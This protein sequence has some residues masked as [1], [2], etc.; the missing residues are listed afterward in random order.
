MRRAVA[1]ALV[2]AFAV[3]GTRAVWMDRMPT[4]GMTERLEFGALPHHLASGGL[5]AGP[6][7]YMPEPQEGCALIWG[8]ACAPVFAVAGPSR[9]SLRWCDILWHAGTAAL[10]ALLAYLAWGGA[11]ALLVG[12][13]WALAPPGVVDAGHDGWVSHI[14]GAALTAASLLA[15]AAAA[16][17]SGRRET[18]ALAGGGVAAS[19]ALFFYAD[20]VLALLPAALALTLLR[21]DRIRTVA[22]AAAAFL[23]TTLAWSGWSGYWFNE[24]GWAAIGGS[25]EP[26]GTGLTSLWRDVLDSWG[27]YG[28]EAPGTPWRE[29]PVGPAT[30]YAGTLLV[31]AAVGIWRAAAGA[32]EPSR[33]PEASRL[34]LWTSAGAVLLHPVGWLA[35]GIELQGRHLLTLWPWL[36][37]AAGAA[38]ASGRLPR[39]AA[40]GLFCAALATLLWTTGARGVVEAADRHPPWADDAVAYAAGLKGYTLVAH[41]G[42]VEATAALTE[43]RWQRTLPRHAADRVELLRLKGRRDAHA[44][45]PPST[46]WSVWQTE[47][48]YAASE[49]SPD[50][51]GA[52]WPEALGR[53]AARGDAAARSEAGS[54]RDLKDVVA[55]APASTR[56]TQCIWLGLFGQELSWTLDPLREPVAWCPP[57][58]FAAGFGVGLA[59][60]IAPIGRPTAAPPDLQ[61][62]TGHAAPPAVQTAFVCSFEEELARALDRSRDQWDRPP[63]ADCLPP[64]PEPPSPS[65]PP[66]P[67]RPGSRPPAD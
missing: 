55:A 10:F 61:W 20:T 46:R 48:F 66:A 9:G 56:R 12:L 45:V 21:R 27:F 18:A 53:A 60:S 13:L 4:W 42:L 37:L 54:W 59:R 22:P 5:I 32:G 11:A 41:P 25:A 67:A 43:E 26:V 30:V 39:A 29:A 44:G 40:A 58:E 63:W 51:V 36:T 2:V 57:D 65:P 3:A 23:V 8:L 52:S 19:L 38:F 14:E 31:L 15:L 64:T 28:H 49:P 47:G 34:V 17:T 7:D 16:H 33:S 24:G 62:W 50:R 1:V 6:A 35:S